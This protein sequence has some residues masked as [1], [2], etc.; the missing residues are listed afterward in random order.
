MKKIHCNIIRDLLPS[1]IDNITSDESNQMIQHHLQECGACQKTY[2]SLKSHTFVSK[3]ADQQMARFFQRNKRKK[4]VEKRVLLFTVLFLSAIQVYFNFFHH[5]D[6]PPLFLYTI[7][8]VLYPGY[9]ILLTM[10]LDMWQNHS[11]PSKRS[12]I[13]L[14]IQGIG[15]IYISALFYYIMVRIGTNVSLPFGLE[16]NKTG[17]FL[18]NQING[19]TAIYLLILLVCL[20]LQG[21][22]RKYN[23]HIIMLSL[24]GITIFFNAR[25]G[26]H[27]LD[28]TVFPMIK[29]FTAT[30]LITVAE[31]ILLEVLYRSIIEKK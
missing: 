16:V 20:I 15:I 25:A 27:Q 12:R 30:L 4:A 1:Y 14:W 11:H 18:V 13:L 24:A 23:F 31:G 8:C 21:R 29:T 17:P 2:D 7:N 6:I 19:L 28:N 26:L 3:K 10:M 5:T 22:G 9:S